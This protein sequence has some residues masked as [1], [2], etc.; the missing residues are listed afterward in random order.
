MLC[1]LTID[2]LP[3]EIVDM[4]DADDDVR[5]GFV[6]GLYHVAVQIREGEYVALRMNYLDGSIEGARAITNG[7]T[8]DEVWALVI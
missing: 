3:Q 2:D 6:D 1:Y 8:I 7:L 5:E 4:I